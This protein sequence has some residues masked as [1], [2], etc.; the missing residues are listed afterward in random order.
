MTSLNT[1]LGKLFTTATKTVDLGERKAYAAFR[2]ECQRRCLTYRIS[3]DSYIKFSDGN[4]MPHYGWDES[5]SRLTSG[6]FQ[7]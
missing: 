2:R 4:A 7:E 3:S 5:L 6:V 1:M